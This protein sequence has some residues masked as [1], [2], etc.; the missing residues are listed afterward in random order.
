M[1][2]VSVDSGALRVF[3]SDAIRC[4]PEVPVIIYT[5]PFN[6]IIY[7]ICEYEKYVKNY[8]GIVL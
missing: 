2:L 7:I 6:I 5:M 8:Y 4:F 1:L 3:E